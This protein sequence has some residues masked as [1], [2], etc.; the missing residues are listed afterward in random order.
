MKQ[1]SPDFLK[2]LHELTTLG[3]KNQEMIR[4][5]HDAIQQMEVFEAFY[6]QG[7]TPAEA[8][9]EYQKFKKLYN[10]IKL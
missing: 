10:S 2:W 4:A 5:D 3:Y 9:I 8:L 7:K 6:N 1:Y